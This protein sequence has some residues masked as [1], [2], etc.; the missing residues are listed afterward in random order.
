MASQL[1]LTFRTLL[2]LLIV[3]LAEPQ[4]EARYLPTRS[5]TDKIDKLRDLLKDLLESDL[6]DTDAQRWRSNLETGTLRWNPNSKY[7]VK[8]EA[9]IN[10]SKSDS[11]RGKEN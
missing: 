1:V 4:V 11:V 10:N 5:N 8:R 9:R 6:D 3:I 7:Y 2:V